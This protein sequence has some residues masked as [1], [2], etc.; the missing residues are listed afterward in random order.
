MTMKLKYK[1]QIKGKLTLETGMHIGGSEVDLEIGGIDK[2]V[3]K[4][5]STN[6][7]K[8]YIPGS[9]LKGKLRDLIARSM[10]YDRIEHD[11]DE[12]FILF[13]DGAKEKHRNTGHLIIRDAFYIGDFNPETGLEEKA[14]NTI[15]RVT[16][17]A[18]P[19]NMERVVR[20][21]TFEL[22]LV[23]DIYT[24]YSVRKKEGYQIKDNQ[25]YTDNQL[26]EKLRLG[27]RLLENDYLGGSGTRGYG[28]V[29]LLFDTPQKIDFKED[30]TTVIT[31]FDFDFNLKADESN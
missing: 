5:K 30:G 21:A 22:D 26:L 16:G 3:V 18:K 7:K 8:P 4:D 27:F 10:G 6:S 14:E 19:R 23:L 9:S 15:N 28:K 17:V 24:N 31:P 2:A 11:V 13:G 29:K 1:I 25:P 12:T 20:G